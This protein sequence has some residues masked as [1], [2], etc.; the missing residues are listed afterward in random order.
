MEEERKG[1]SFL[2]SFYDAARGLKKP[3]LQA[4]FLMAICDYALN[5]NERELSD[6]AMVPFILVKP[7]LEKSRKRAK[8]GSSGGRGNKSEKNKNKANEKQN[9]NK[10]KA[11]EKQTASNPL[12]RSKEIG[13]RSKEIINKDI[14]PP[15][16][17]NGGGGF[18]EDLLETIKFWE[19]RFGPISSTRVE[20][21]KDLLEDY[22]K[23]ISLYAIGEA[24]D[25]GGGWNYVTTV[26]R[27]ET[28]RRENR[29]TNRVSNDTG[30]PELSDP[31]LQG[32]YEQA[33]RDGNV[34]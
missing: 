19:Q 33:K 3:E 13:D 18:S 11:N 14:P 12:Y 21:L 23:E 2:R 24:A 28:V 20:T 4:E 22:G 1:F 25:H 5:G 9:K 26:A 31:Y 17:E 8:A 6:D 27:N 32:L 15:E 29:G 16:E 10:L 34:V 7:I 30:E